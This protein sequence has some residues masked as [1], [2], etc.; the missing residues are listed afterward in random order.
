MNISQKSISAI[1][2]LGI[3][4]IN[5]S[6]SGHPGVVL[7]AAPMAYSLFTNH[8]NINPKNSN[9]FNRDRFVLAAGHGSML[10]YGM[11]HLCGYDVSMED[12][13]NFRQWG[14]KTPGHP[15][16]KHTDGVDATSGPLGQ[17]IP[18][19]AG[20]ALASSILAK[21][22]NKENF[23]VI[24]HMNYAICGDGDL[25]EGVTSE[26][27]SLAGKLQ[28]GNLVV[29]Y[30]SND[31]CLDGDL[32]KTFKDDVLKRYESYGWH[33]QKVEDGTD[34][35]AI[36]K[37]IEEAK[38]ETERPSIIEIKTIIGHGS[39]KQGTCDVHGA[40]LGEEDG[41]FAKASYGWGY[42][43]F[44]VPDE[45]YADF[46]EKVADKGASVNK[47][48]GEMLAE[49][50]K[51][52]PELAAELE[53][54]MSGDLLVDLEA[55]MPK[56]EVG[57]SDATRNTNNE[58]IN[59][60]AK[61]LPNFLGGSAD[62]SHSNKTNIKNT[63]DYSKET[64]DGR[65]IN[66]GVREF[67]MASMLNGMALHGGL[68]VFGGTFFVFSDYL[69]PAVRMAAIMGLP[70]TYVLTHDSI[71]VGED[72]PTHE[73]I[74]QLAT[75]RALPNMVTYRPADATETAAAWRLAVES[76][77]HPTALVLTRQNVTTMAGTN[78]EGV[79][80]G[81]YI[82]SEASGEL[83]GI[84]IASGSEVNLAVTAQKALEA[85]GI[86]TRVVSMPSMESFDKQSSEYKEAVLPRNTRKRLAIEM[87]ASL[88][89]DRYTGLDGKVLA[90]DKFGASAPAEKVIAE[91]GFTVENVV[92]LYKTL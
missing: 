67:A 44:F 40:P 36:S 65:N 45:V 22:Y 43:P 63:S 33:V 47:A 39:A 83:D 20:M 42:E 64:P 1:R 11:L 21:R 56:Y 88:G 6:K 12:L 2:A 14:S 89:W 80:K 26:A 31:I 70:V 9:W 52:Y 58:A 7:G 19:A 84:L 49:Y 92:G 17:G 38:K 3:D 77:D 35:V 13:K 74:E 79:K 48:W 73:P 87:G 82:V 25:M 62:L 57:H 46:K 71:A 59:A 68:K 61:A 78:Y 54:V 29:L 16:F 69:K 41:K 32:S 85:E 50:K 51:E 66:F 72:G 81:G 90:I 23:K 8:M 86:Y 53:T 4:A 37:A 5:K 18:M 30:D 27:S 28:L 60:I 10:L 34:I 24:D 76:K 91:Y 55:V 75:L 15:E